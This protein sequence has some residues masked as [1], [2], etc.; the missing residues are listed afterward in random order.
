MGAADS[1]FIG[2]LDIFGFENFSVIAF[3][4]NFFGDHL[5]I[6]FFEQLCINWANEKLQQQ[7]NHHVFKLE[8][9]EYDKEGIDW[10]V[11]RICYQ[12]YSDRCRSRISFKDNEECIKL[13][14]D[15]MGIISILDEE[16]R[17]PKV[18]IQIDCKLMY[19]LCG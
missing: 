7:F 3:V 12:R 9:E 14:E 2:V 11:Q 15:K 1:Y 17:F 10:C 16:C 18:R 8:Q 4:G 6:N 13:I 5:K 19:I